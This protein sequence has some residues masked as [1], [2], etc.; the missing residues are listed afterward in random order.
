[1]KLFSY[2]RPFRYEEKVNESS[3]SSRKYEKDDFIHRVYASMA[4]HHPY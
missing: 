3:E 2:M 1:M 4:I